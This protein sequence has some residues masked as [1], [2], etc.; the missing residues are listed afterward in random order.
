MG[1]VKLQRVS[2]GSVRSLDVPGTGD[3]EAIERDDIDPVVVVA[4]WIFA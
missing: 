1:P 3:D 2:H 4:S